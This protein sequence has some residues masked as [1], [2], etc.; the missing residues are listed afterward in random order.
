M[1]QLG[2]AHWA[3]GVAEWVKLKASARMRVRV[4][5]RRLR[6]YEGYVKAERVARVRV[7]TR[8]RLLFRGLGF[9]LLLCCDRRE[10]SLRRLG[11]GHR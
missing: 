5:V 10:R 6:A 9:G 2:L 11:K 8:S 3:H 7:S 1:E 4:R